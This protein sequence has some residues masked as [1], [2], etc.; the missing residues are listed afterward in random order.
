MAFGKFLTKRAAQGILLM[1]GVLTLVFFFSRLLPGDATLVYLAPGIPPSIADQ[2]RT[3]L[4]LDRPIFEQFVRWIASFVQGELGY[5]T[6]HN[7]PVLKVLLLVF[8][9]TLALG[10]AAIILEIAIAVFLASI[11]SLKPGSFFD[12]IVVSLT[13]AIYAIPAFWIGMLLLVFLSYQLGVFPSS[14]MFSFGVSWSDGVGAFPDLAWHLVLPAITIALPGGAGLARFLRTSIQSTLSSDFVLGA[15]SL[16]LST[17]QIFWKYVIPNSIGPM[18]ALLGVEIGIVMGGTVLTE[19]LFG[20]PGFGRLAVTAIFA[21]DYPLILGCTAF[22]GA[23]VI[24][25][26]AMA[27]IIHALIDPRIRFGLKT[28]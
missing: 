12:N 24:A 28:T 1:L 14:Q 16:G 25:S 23:V 6:T 2:L 26:N 17:K 18:V 4:G 15:R 19:T 8:P 22:S 10:L 27:D 9:N 13:L 7:A 20:W 5:S 11:A 21:R 3:Q